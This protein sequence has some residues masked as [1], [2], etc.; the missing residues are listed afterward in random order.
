MPSADDTIEVK[1]KKRDV[2]SWTGR[3]KVEVLYFERHLVIEDGWAERD[4]DGRYCTV[5]RV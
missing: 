5:F 2:L 4:T 3:N 1:L